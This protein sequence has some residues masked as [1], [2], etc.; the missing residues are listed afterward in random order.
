MRLIAVAVIA[1]AAFG[2]WEHIRANYNAGPLD[3]RYADHWA[4]MSAADRWWKA[5]TKGVGPSPILAPGILVQAALCTLAATFRH[6]GLGGPR[7]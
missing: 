2:I 6:P 1:M 7:D 3:F 4:T 5:A